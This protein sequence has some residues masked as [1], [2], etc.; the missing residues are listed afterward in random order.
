MNDTQQAGA[1]NK[2]RI[3]GR[4]WIVPFVL[5]CALLV[6]MLQR[7]AI[8]KQQIH[9]VYAHEQIEIFHEMVER[10]RSLGSQGS[11]GK[12]EYVQ[13]YYPSGTKQA[14]GS[15]ID[16]IVEACREF[17]IDEIQWIGSIDDAQDLSQQGS[18]Q[19]QAD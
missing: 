4:K 12:I 18:D 8:V 5:A 3:I 2:F 15:Q 13:H 10:S 9:L 11:A 6:V 7:A 16:R 1:N 17:A 14:A 19:T